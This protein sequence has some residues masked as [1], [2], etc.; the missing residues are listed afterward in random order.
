MSQQRKTTIELVNKS[1]AKRYRAEKRFKVL[2][3]SA[4]VISLVFLSIL[5]ATISY[6]GRTA[7]QQTWLQLNVFFEPQF[8]DTTNL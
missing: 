5:F 4:I 7:F 1:L 8:F 2:G 3:L 6:N